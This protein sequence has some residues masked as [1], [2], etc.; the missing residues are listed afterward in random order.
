MVVGFNHN[1]R[2]KG[3]IYH[4]QTEDSGLKSP[5]IVTLLYRGG[6]ILASK[7]MS[8]AD[9][10]KIDNLERVV[11][12]LMKDQHKEM[13]RALKSGQFDAVIARYEAGLVKEGA[14]EAT[15]ETPPAGSTV[16]E[17]PTTSAAPSQTPP[18]GPVVSSPQPPRPPSRISKSLDDIVLS[19]LTG[20][21]DKDRSKP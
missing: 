15:E 20:E 5:N 10:S 6:T 1:F 14:G 16:V 12:E 4:I 19:Y 2:Y 18:S 3:E 7:K 13:L 11:E 9:I 8:Y 17:N 21:E